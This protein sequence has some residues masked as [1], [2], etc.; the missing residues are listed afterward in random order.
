MSSVRP[1]LPI[2]APLLGER[3]IRYVVAA[4]EAGEI[5]GAYGRFRD[6][7]ERE[8]AKYCGCSHGIATSSGT[9]ALHLALASLGIGPGDEVLVSTLTF[10]STFFAVLY[11]SATPIPVDITED[12]WNLDPDLLEGLVN[13]RT[14][15][16]IVVHLYGNPADMEPIMKFAR[17]HHLHVIEDA[18]E[19]HG[20]IYKG[21]KVGSIGDV[22]CFSFFANKIVTTGEGGM[23]TTNNADIAERARSL[24]SLAY[25][26][27]R[28]FMH[29]DIGFNYRLSSLQAA[30]GCAQLERIEEVIE[31]KRR[32]A[33]FY[34]EHLSELSE[35]QLPIE[36]PCTRNVYWMYHIVLRGLRAKNRDRVMQLLLERGIETRA[37]F[38]PYNR[39]EV[40][41]H[42]GLTQPDLCPIANRIADTGLYLPSSP[43]LS[44]EELRFVAE[45]LRDVLRQLGK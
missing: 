35:I 36:K 37:A 2:T 18:A 8:F 1:F 19:A 39:Q 30:L 7:F 24:C 26:Q 21:D 23:V 34:N 33:R 17:R 6:R 15:A 40:F 12:T 9:T 11:Q 3:E 43:T 42:R 14:K 5:S 32:V 4:L 29:I 10:M 28:K 25:G 45:N 27:E 38:I 44:A 13:S 41:I 31:N 20:A 16:I 22:G